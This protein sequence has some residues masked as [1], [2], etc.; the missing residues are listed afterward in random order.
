[1]RQVFIKTVSDEHG[2]VSISEGTFQET[3]VEDG[4]AD[5]VVVAQVARPFSSMRHFSNDPCRPST[6]AQTL[7][8]L[9]RSL[10]AS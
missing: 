6:G 9:R 8:A 3:H 10:D 2:R 4:W 1:M 5:L 7:V